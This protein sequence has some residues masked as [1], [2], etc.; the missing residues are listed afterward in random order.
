MTAYYL[1]F[2]PQYSATTS[3]LNQLLKKEAPWVCTT[4]CQ[5]AV[6]QLKRRL[7]TAPILTHLYLTSP[8]LITCD[9]SATVFGAILSHLQ[10]GMEKPIAF[11]SRALSPTEQKYLVGEHEALEC[12]WACER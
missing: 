11:S 5:E 12:V 1:S 9:A 7:T 8:T 3:P 10:N 4:D 2:L 6:C